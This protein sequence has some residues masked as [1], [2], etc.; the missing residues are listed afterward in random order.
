MDQPLRIDGGYGEGGGQIL[1]T[2]FAL[3]CLTKRP[4]E[5]YNIRRGRKNPGLQP[6]HLTSALAAQKISSAD[7]LGA[8][9]GSQ[10][11][12]FVP[13]VPKGGSYS[14][15]VSEKRGSAGSI[16][17]V[18]Q[19]I[20]LPLSFA[21]TGS[22]IEV[23]GG[24]HVPWSPPFHYLAHVFLPIVNRMGLDIKIMIERWG[25]YPKG[26]GIIRAEVSPARSLSSIDLKERG[27]LKKIWGVSAVSNLPRSIAER[28]R[29]TAS[30]ILKDD[31]FIPE[32][33]IVDAPSIGQ[34][35]FILIVIEFENS[36]VGFSS[37]GQ[38]GKR[39]EEVGEEAA[40]AFLD[41]YSSGAAVDPHL[42]DQILPYLALAKGE[43]AMTTS[44]I[45]R[46]LLTNIWLIEQFIPIKFTVEGKEG[47]KGLIRVS[48]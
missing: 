42:A 10:T 13:K 14:L 27:E 6:Q 30:K 2:A 8:E 18:L 46:H 20:L 15:N 5:I 21:D 33:D 7:I 24:T 12:R 43:S 37:L 25:F 1:R 47:E 4:I 9:L 17:L 36:I 28:Q 29:D 48:T 3:S 39:A 35:T 41:F 44:K 16:P 38:R 31:G 26:G 19:T 23:I 40:R 22:K 34:G 11:L 45:S 32:I